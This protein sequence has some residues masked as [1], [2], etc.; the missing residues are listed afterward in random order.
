MCDMQS[1]PKA[2]T[3]CLNFPIP[4]NRHYYKFSNRGLQIAPVTW[5]AGRETQAIQCC[6][7]SP[8]PYSPH[9]VE[10][11]TPG[12]L[13]RQPPA[14]RPALTMHDPPLD[15][16]LDNQATNKLALSV[17]SAIFWQNPANLD[18]SK[19]LYK[20]VRIPSRSGT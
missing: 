6:L 18:L 2:N 5:P 10:L 4:A 7:V 3:S 20:W 14:H 15:M 11:Q 16:L 8:S 9:Q 19:S 12:Y 1:P 17:P 13:L